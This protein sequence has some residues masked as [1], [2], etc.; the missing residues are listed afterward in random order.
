MKT[1]FIFKEHKNPIE[2]LRFKKYNQKILVQEKTSL[3][4]QLLSFVPQTD[5]MKI[6]LSGLQVWQH[7][8]TYKHVCGAFC[9]Y[10]CI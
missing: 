5:Y 8:H 2:D 1:S 7:I 9:M 6:H 10:L 4:N 3:M